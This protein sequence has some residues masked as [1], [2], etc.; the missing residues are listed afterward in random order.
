MRI[1]DHQT[2]EHDQN[3]NSYRISV[4]RNIFELL[5]R[6]DTHADALDFVGYFSMDASASRAHENKE[7][8]DDIHGSLNTTRSYGAKPN[9]VI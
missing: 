1:R 8:A 4:L 7:A 6:E 3:V 5:L 2:N 9:G